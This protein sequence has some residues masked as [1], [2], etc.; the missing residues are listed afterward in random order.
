MAQRQLIKKWMIKEARRT[1]QWTFGNAILYK[2]CAK[3]PRHSS[4]PKVV[5]KVWLIGRAYAA[6]IERVRAPNPEVKDFY[7]EVVA[8]SIV[9]SKIDCWLDALS[10]MRLSQGNTAKILQVHRRV[11]D[12]FNGM[13]EMNK[14]SLASKYLHFHF[15]NLFF[16][17][18]TRVQRALGL[19]S[20]I[21]GRA[22]RKPDGDSYDN[23]YRKVFE[24]CLALREHIQDKHGVTLTPRQLDTLLIGPVLRTLE[25]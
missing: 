9:K 12:L 10:G 5:A 18:D 21:V 11:M 3:H 22:T 13:M 17:Y 20:P 4:A 19:L 15:P 16:L 14:R 2:L 1:N 24:K 8:P 25:Q 7:L 23:E 6:A